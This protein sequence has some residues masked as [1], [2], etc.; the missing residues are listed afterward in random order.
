MT[1]ILFWIPNIENYGI[2]SKF[3][4]YDIYAMYDIWPNHKRF[5]KKQKLVN[6]SKE[7]YYDENINLGKKTTPNKEYLEEFEK[8][9]GIKLWETYYAEKSFNKY[10]PYYK[11]S[12]S[13]ALL[14]FEQE[15]KFFESILDEIRPDYLIMQRVA[16]HQT[17][18]L[19]E[20]CKSRNIPVLTLEV[21]N[22]G[23]RFQICSSMENISEE[24][25]KYVPQKQFSK[26]EL[27]NYF[28][29]YDS[30]KQNKT[31]LTKIPS[32][33]VRNKDVAKNFI[34]HDNK[35]F[36]KHFARL[37]MSRFN[38]IK[39]S[40]I[41]I[42]KKSNVEKFVKQNLEYKINTKNRFIYFPLHTEPEAVLNLESKFF[43]N[44]IEVIKHIAK[45]LP[46]SHIL[47]VKD[48]PI[49][50][51]K[52]SRDVNFYN[53]IQ[54]IPNVVLLHHSISRDQIIKN[55]DLVITIAGTSGLEAMF[56]DKPVIVLS[57][58]SYSIIPFIHKI[59][60][61]EQLSNSIR[62][63]LLTKTDFE[64]LATY[65]DFI[66]N[67]S[68]ELDLVSINVDMN[69]R[70]YTMGIIT[71]DKTL[72]HDEVIDFLNCHDKAFEKIHEQFLKK[73]LI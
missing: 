36:Q 28:F 30:S 6:F 27:F 73:M 40:I 4:E 10:N 65:V 15:C 5:F 42:I 63:A 52:N 69:Y 29:Q 39:Q 59:Q 70:F 64:T 46:A 19:S 57:N 2:A 56:F 11:F 34:F 53:E 38:M 66:L 62:D 23:F 21:S 68:F 25:K 51:L 17:F 14:I 31:L 49:S 9:T 55:C 32:I 12:Y 43:T 41:S 72:L 16:R 7:W 45:S 58:P 61:M 20:I 13:E 26:Q 3:K 67:K 44:Q 35:K 24:F 37:G 60:N 71:F 54:K 48:H 33:Y 22:F 8:R 47:Y 50:T 18:L 1:K